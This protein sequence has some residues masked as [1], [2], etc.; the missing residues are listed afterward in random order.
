[1]NICVTNLSRETSE[2]AVRYA[3]S[4]FGQVRLVSVMGDDTTGE[5]KALVS[6][7]IEHEA[8]AAIG[9]I[10]GKTLQGRIVQAVGQPGT[11]ILRIK[12]TPVVSRQVRSRAGR[13][14]RGRAGRDGRS[15]AG[16][17]GR[18]RAHRGK[19]RK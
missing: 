2:D 18:G 5:C 7:P 12:D 4:A 14:V 9:A 19:R 1:M 16:R 10:N 3:F 6:M 17:D 13:E 11:N 8:R 15:K